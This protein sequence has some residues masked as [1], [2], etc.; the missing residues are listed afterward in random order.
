MFVL[1][2]SFLLFLF[3]VLLSALKEAAESQANPRTDQLLA[4]SSKK[5]ILLLQNHKSSR[6]LCFFPFGH[7]KIN[8]ILRIFQFHFK[9]IM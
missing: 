2:T 7:K 5:F 1:A 3:F 9:Q 6:I 4:P 8:T